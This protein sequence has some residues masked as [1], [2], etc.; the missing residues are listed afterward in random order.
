MHTYTHR[1]TY[2]PYTYMHTQKHKNKELGNIKWFNNGDD[3]SGFKG[4]SFVELLFAA[5]IFT[6]IVSSS[7]F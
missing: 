4:F 1:P 7:K 2:R 3:V 5:E 6:F